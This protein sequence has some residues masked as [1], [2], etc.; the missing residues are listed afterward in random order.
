VYTNSFVAHG[1][2]VLMPNGEI[3]FVPYNAEV[4]QKISTGA[5]VPL[6]IVTAAYFNGNL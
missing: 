6:G 2:G 1:G 4:G 3:H 5:E